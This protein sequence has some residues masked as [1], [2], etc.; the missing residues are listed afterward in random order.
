MNIQLQLCDSGGVYIFIYNPIISGSLS[1]KSFF[2]DAFEILC[3]EMESPT[4][5]ERL[6][7]H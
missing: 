5:I 4:W 3:M 2:D 7:K 6:L 1:L